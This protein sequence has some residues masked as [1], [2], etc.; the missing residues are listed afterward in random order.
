[1]SAS[2]T[3]VVD[4][5]YDVTA[6]RTSLR[7]MRLTNWVL[8][9]LVAGLLLGAAISATDN[10]ALR[11]LVSMLEPLGTLWVNAIRMT[12]IPLVISLLVV[13]VASL[14]DLRAIRRLGARALLVFL[15]LLVGAAVAAAAIAPAVFA[16]LTIDP[17]ASAALRASAAS[18]AEA[19]AEGMRSLPT[20]GQWLV[21][22]VPANP[23]KAAADGA[24]LPLIV[25]T[26]LFAIALGRLAPDARRTIV[27]GFQ[28]VADTMMTLVR[29]V[30]ALAPI[31]VFALIVPLAAR[32]GVA[33]AGAVAYFVVAVSL[34]F[35][36]IVAL[37]YP[38]AAIG[39]R[40]SVRR[41]ARA[42]LPA[43]VVALTSSSSIASLPAL[44][45]GAER[46]LGIPRP[47]TGFVLP[48]A[49]ATF[50][51]A[52]PVGWSVAPLFLARLYGVDLGAAD[53]ATLVF[54]A[55]LTSF[56]TPGVPQGGYLLLAPVLVSVG[57]PAEGVGILIAVD[58]I[59]DRFATLLNVTGD[60]TAT[61]VVARQPVAVGSD[62][63]GPP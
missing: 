9:A 38:V 52:T 60:L 59:P 40:V 37:L 8:V 45:D 55:I 25:F 41:F 54:T 1:M 20:F 43:Q 58:A 33:A 7:S 22:L 46:G 31:G 57:L 21:S 51:I 26:L 48:L 15:V 29:G 44:I 16:G 36:L 13:G 6:D 50:K 30:I 32:M 53:M 61:A 34:A 4:A 56:S 28:A 47:I 63:T 12:V 23:I 17:R 49:V 42:A 18:S 19:M 35:L 24:M 5:P 39:G 2:V 11:G 3:T 27:G 10:A 14:S 62:E